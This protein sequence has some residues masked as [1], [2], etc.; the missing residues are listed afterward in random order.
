MGDLMRV[1]FFDLDGTLLDTLGDIGNACN[2]ILAR[3]GYPIHPLADYRRFVGRGFDKLVRDTL[4]AA[5]ELEAPALAQL[6][7]ETRQHYGRHM[8]DTTRPYAGILPA[9]ET[10]AAK[11][12]PL[13]VLSNKPEEHTVELVKRYFPSIPFALVRGGR[14][15]VPLK[16]EPHALLDMAETMHTSVAR[17]LYVGDS[18][19]DVQTA[20]N[21][22]TT[23]VGVA[24]GFRGPA[25]LRAAGADHIIDTPSQLIELTV[26]I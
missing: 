5:A 19:V 3:H 12:C 11:G 25:E 4:P 8:Y 26:E 10:L 23:S 1:F 24:W 15:N 17:V 7:E 9:L 21:A 16:P 20:R 14:K 18:D 22:G 6:V 13:A 2:T